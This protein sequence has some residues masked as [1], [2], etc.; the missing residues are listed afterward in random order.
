MKEEM[1]CLD[2]W[3]YIPPLTQRCLLLEPIFIWRQTEFDDF[4]INIPVIRFISCL[5][6]DLSAKTMVYG[7]SI[8][9]LPSLKCL[10]G[11]EISVPILILSSSF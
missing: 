2:S 5:P 9:W 1:I 8:L 11:V 7:Q 10:F 3:R 6:L 4:D